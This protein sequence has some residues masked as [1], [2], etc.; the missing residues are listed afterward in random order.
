M[1][2]QRSRRFPRSNTHTRGGFHQRICWSTANCVHSRSN[3]F[4]NQINTSQRR[5]LA[6]SEQIHGLIR[7]RQILT[8]SN[9]YGIPVHHNHRRHNIPTPIPRNN[10]EEGSRGTNG[11]VVSDHPE[12]VEEN[13]RFSQQL[14]N[15]C[16]TWI[17]IM[18][19][20]YARINELYLRTSARLGHANLPHFNEV[21]NTLRNQQEVIAQARQRAEIGGL[22]EITSFLFETLRAV[23]FFN[24]GLDQLEMVLNDPLHRLN[25]TEQENE[26]G[27]SEA[28]LQSLPTTD[29][30]IQQ[31][32]DGTKC[33]VCLMDYSEGEIV[34]QLSCGHL[35]HCNCITTWL[36]TKTTCPTCRRNLQEESIE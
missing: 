29:I 20:L 5:R 25:M 1:P 10:A 21:L 7:Q 22:D 35:Y 24:N 2:S 34:C 30:S 11:A 12:A 36:T 14:F 4:F 31:V 17:T 32:Q 9:Q 8:L 23:T 16:V 3:H 28:Q 13:N 33:N 15:V 18:D 19:Q 26:T 27:L 6:Q